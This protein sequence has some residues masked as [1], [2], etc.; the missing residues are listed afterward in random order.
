MVFSYNWLQ[1]FF[2]KKL[3][4]PEKLAE[5]LTMHSFEIEG[6][7]KID[8]DWA[9]DIDVLSNR[10]SDCFSHLGIAREIFVIL[11]LPMKPENNKLKEDKSAKA[12]DYIK[13]EVKDVKLCSRYT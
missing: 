11:N 10:G 2:S 1:L 13:V 8:N 12:K 7:K 5:V 9:M 3:P 4:K 6:I